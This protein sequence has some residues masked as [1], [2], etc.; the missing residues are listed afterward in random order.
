MPQDQHSPL[1]VEIPTLEPDETLVAAL[2][3]RSRAAAPVAVPSQRGRRTVRLGAA[4]AGLG[5]AVGGVGIV[6]AQ[7]G[8][9]EWPDELPGRPAP[10]SPPPGSSTPGVGESDAPGSDGPDSP[11][12]DGTPGADPTQSGRPEHGRKGGRSNDAPGRGD[13]TPGPDEHANERGSERG[14]GRSSAGDPKDGTTRDTTTGTTKD[15]GEERRADPQ[16]ARPS[17]PDEQRESRGGGR[18]TSSEGRGHGPG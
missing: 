17:E 9:L 18:S 4:V 3:D 16:D 1:R 6:A 11:G 15:T 14:S 7:T 5:L 2:V 8:H 12:T 13:R 10:V